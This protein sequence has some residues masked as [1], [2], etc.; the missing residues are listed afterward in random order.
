ML[1]CALG[2]G[3]KIKPGDLEKHG[4]EC[5][6]KTVDCPAKDIFCGWTGPRSDVATHLSS[7]QYELIRNNPAFTDVLSRVP[8]SEQQK[9]TLSSV[10]PDNEENR[11]SKQP[12]GQ[13]AKLKRETEKMSQTVLP[14]AKVTGGSYKG[15]LVEVI[16]RTDNQA[17]VKLKTIPPS[18]KGNKVQ[19]QVTTISISS[20][21]VEGKQV[22]SDE[23]DSSADENDEESEEDEIDQVGNTLS[24]HDNIK[25]TLSPTALQDMGHDY[26]PTCT[27]PHRCNAPLY[28]NTPCPNKPTLPNAKYCSECHAAGPNG[29]RCTEWVA[30][31]EFSLLYCAEHNKR[32]KK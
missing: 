32:K 9:R 5:P 15:A 20:L 24:D 2:C 19:D 22:S 29:K 23:Y 6:A 3:Q 4:S 26:R 11:Q 28:D 21:E 13:E 16:D 17:T 25:D 7:C 10:T 18:C 1:D 12:C 27:Y 8:K 14:T 30:R 31:R